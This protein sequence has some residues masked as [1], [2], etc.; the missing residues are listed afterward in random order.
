MFN[1]FKKISI[2]YD[3]I[4]RTAKELHDFIKEFVKCSYCFNNENENDIDLMN[5]LNKNI[6]HIFILIY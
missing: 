2:I 5:Q 6:I 4:K 1:K 3:E